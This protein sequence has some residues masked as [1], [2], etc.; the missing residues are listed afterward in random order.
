[1]ARGVAIVTL[2]VL[3]CAVANAHNI[4][5]AYRFVCGPNGAP[6]S[7]RVM[8]Y[9]DWDLYVDLD[10][11][12]ATM[13]SRFPGRTSG[14]PAG[15]PNTVRLGHPPGCN[16][17]SCAG[18]GNTNLP[19]FGT[20]DPWTPPSEY[21]FN[22]PLVTNQAYVTCKQANPASTTCGNVFNDI[23]LSGYAKWQDG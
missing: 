14:F 20:V 19:A 2:F 17:S 9:N 6:D 12:T 5:T 21:Y 3:F 1:M 15:F 13:N 10:T 16:P 22:M 23:I 18:T 4:L 7:I 8:L 11:S